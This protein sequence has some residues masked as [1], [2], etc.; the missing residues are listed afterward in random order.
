MRLVQLVLLGLG[1]A[2]LSCTEPPPGGMTRSDAAAGDH[3]TMMGEGG[4]AGGEMM[5]AAGGGG[6][7]GGEGG[8]MGGG[9]GMGGGGMG[10]GGGGG[11]SDG[12]A[13]KDGKGA[14]SGDGPKIKVGDVC[15]AATACPAGGSGKPICRSAWPGGYCLVEGCQDHGHDCP[16]D[17]G[18]NGTF[19]DSK[20]VLAPT[21][22]C[23][24]MCKS[25]ADCRQGY[26]CEQ[27]SDAAGH[28]SANVCVPK[29]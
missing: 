19:G 26:S 6:M 21:A 22:T 5:G 25:S 9:G 17:P 16:G 10:G 18:L 3:R 4:G 13:A 2:L 29:P 24:K 15:D 12:G 1:L 23:L 28:G 7:M 14:A 8:M 11:M 20:C 27:K